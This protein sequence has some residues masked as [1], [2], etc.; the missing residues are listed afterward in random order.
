M[1]IFREYHNR[2]LDDFVMILLQQSFSCIRIMATLWLLALLFAASE[3]A[4]G[5]TSDAKTDAKTDA[6]P[7]AEIATENL[8]DELVAS[9]EYESAA[10]ATD[11]EIC[12][13]VGKDIL[14]EGGSAVDSAIASLICLGTVQFQSSGL[15]GGGF[16][17][18]YDKATRKMHAFD[19]RE[20]VPKEA[21]AEVFNKDPEKAANGKEYSA[22]AVQVHLKNT[23]YHHHNR[24][25][26]YHHN[27]RNHHHN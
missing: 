27:H 22:P 26:Y 16:L 11:S 19:F 10:V 21:K 2:R 7:K 17:L 6:A 15:G 25:H 5:A 13:N 14:Q 8:T 18:N 9:E 1:A 4:E 3:Q 23:F 20:T 24:N 12:S